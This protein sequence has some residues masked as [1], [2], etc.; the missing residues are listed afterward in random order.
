MSNATLAAALTR[1]RQA[2]EGRSDRQLLEAYATANDQAAF[3][4]LVRR[5]GSMVLGVCRR[6]LHDVHNAEDAFQAVFLTLARKANLLDKGEALTGWL[7]RV[8]Y[9]AALRARRDAAR[10]RKHEGRVAPRTNPPAW[11]V[12]WRELQG[13]LDE[14]MQRLPA[15]YRDVFVL[16]C[17]DGLS[18]PAVAKRLGVGENTVFSRLARARKRLREQLARRGISLSAVLTALAV[19]GT[20]RAA[21]PPR[22][23]RSVSEAATRLGA[24]TPVTGLSAKALSLAEGVTTTMLSNKFKLAA[25][26]LL[27]LCA[28]GIGLGVFARP[29][30]HEAASFQL[31]EEQRQVSDLPPRVTATKPTADTVIVR[32]RVVGADREPV[33]GAK[34]YLTLMHGYA[35]EPFPASVLATT[36]PDGGFQFT[37]PKA[38]T[39]E[40][41]TVVA[42]VAANH[43]VGW[44]EVP[45]GGGGDGLT[46]RLVKDVPI[47]GQVVDL[48][49]KPVPGATLR[50]LGIS[51]APGEDLGPWLAAPQRK[52]DNF[53]FDSVNLSEWGLKVTTNREGRIQLSGIGRNRLVRARLDGP[54]IASQYLHLITRSGKTIIVS[55]AERKLPPTITYYAANFR[56]VASPTKPVVGVVR[57]KD[58]RKPMAGLTVESHT[59]ANNPVPGNNLVRTTTDAQGR[60]TLTGLPKGEGNSIQFVPRSDQP[61]VRVYVPVPDSPGLGPVSLDFALKRG[62]WIE[63]KLT[64]KRTGKP[65]RGYVDYFALAANSNVDDYPGF[66]G[67]LH[68]SFVQTKEDGSFRVVGLPGPGLI[69]VFYTGEHLL[70]T[71]ANASRSADSARICVSIQAQ[72]CL[73][74]RHN[75]SSP[76]DFEM[77]SPWLATERDDE[78][79]TKEQYLNTSGRL[80]GLLINYTALARIDPAKGALA[81]KRDITLDPGWTFT[82]TVLGPDGKPLAGARSFGLNSRGGWNRDPL[83]TAEFTVQAFNPRR[84]RELLFQHPDKGLVGVAQPPKQRGDTITVRLE[85]GATITGRL[86]DNDGKPRAGVEV[87]L[88]SQ[89]KKGQILQQYSPERSKTDREGRFRFQALLPGREYSLS[90]GKNPSPLGVAPRLGQ[91]KDLGDVKIK[92]VE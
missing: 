38:A 55:A 86:V 76:K 26:F 64:D 13:V 28:L 39:G 31:A 89:V 25:V 15:A 65:L 91:T 81:V 78:Y 61:Y 14:E 67:T 54:T 69:A 72:F 34:L 17:L 52:K 49:G 74:G 16:C 66:A 8:S 20:S 40:H 77:R 48:E 57:D 53:E 27:S 80:L 19:S 36:G 6:V 41:K 75:C 30:P 32:G 62:V 58:T 68:A 71:R 83:K 1:L 7:H 33:P 11:E 84:P 2:A 22:L 47:T 46:I 51:A 70:A 9:R 44:L 87:D 35:R 82:G 23:A 79:G 29:A 63:G 60:Y 37:V 92:P 43:G 18:G 56:H 88:W 59:L 90:D 42:A 45:A 12:G 73:Y 50:V 3:A 4:A 85:P 5:H 21:L 10:R 24:G